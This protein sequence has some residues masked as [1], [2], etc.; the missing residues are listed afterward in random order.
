MDRRCPAVR[1]ACAVLIAAS[2]AAY[3]ADVSAA[4]AATVNC[5]GPLKTIIRQLPALLSR[6][7]ISSGGSVSDDVIVLSQPEPASA[8]AQEMITARTDGRSGDGIGCACGLEV[9]RVEETAGERRGLSHITPADDPTRAKADAQL[10]R[11]RQ[12]VDH[13]PVDPHPI[14]PVRDEGHVLPANVGTALRPLLRQRD[15][16]AEASLLVS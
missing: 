11:R 1:F 5:V 2:S 8:A 15:R 13:P 12:R 4:G 9:E 6:L 14:H 7:T 16:D 10:P 3:A